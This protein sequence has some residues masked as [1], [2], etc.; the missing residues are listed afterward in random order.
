[1]T[2]VSRADVLATFDTPP[3]DANKLS[4]ID[5]LIAS[6]TEELAAE[7]GFTFDR[8]PAED[9]ETFAV[10]A[11]GGKVLHLHGD[12]LG[13]AEVPT[14]ISF[15]PN[16]GVTP[17]LIAEAD[18]LVEQWDPSSGQYDHIRLPGTTTGYSDFP[19]GYGLVVID[20][21]RGFPRMPDAAQAAVSDRVR[22]LF[23]ADPSLVGGQ[24]G[25]EEGGRV[26]MSP[27]WPDTFYKVVRHYRTRYATC[28]YR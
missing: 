5:A 7:L 14:S 9:T 2:T 6:A 27:R 13:L 26:L 23:H 1:M 17:V 24:A 28:Y 16:F 8:L 25:P 15:A 20:G 19:I 11:R 22:Q 18:Y 3:T 10:E 21:A 4:R 12:T